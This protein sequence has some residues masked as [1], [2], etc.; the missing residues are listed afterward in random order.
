MNEK[1]TNAYQKNIFI[2][3]VKNKMLSNLILRTHPNQKVP[4]PVLP[5]MR[6]IMIM[7][8]NSNVME[9]T[10]MVAIFWK[11]ELLNI[12]LMSVFLSVNAM[13]RT[14]QFKQVKRTEGTRKKKA[15]VQ[16]A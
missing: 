2:R 6:R 12:L 16:K 1:I 5:T 15:T 3:S 13:Q 10:D 14:I 4:L 7:V 9:P 11:T 8:R